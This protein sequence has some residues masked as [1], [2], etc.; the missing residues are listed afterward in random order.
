MSCL[1]LRGKDVADKPREVCH[2]LL[3]RCFVSEHAPAVLLNSYLFLNHILAE[4]IY[5]RKIQN[6]SMRR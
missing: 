4:T 2:L 3:E 6:Q 5:K 1:K